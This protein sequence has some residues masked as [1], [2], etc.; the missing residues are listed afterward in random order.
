M[1]T[2]E[3]RQTY[4]DGK[5][6]PTSGELQAMCLKGG[7]G[8]KREMLKVGGWDQLA[9]IATPVSRLDKSAVISGTYWLRQGS[10]RMLCI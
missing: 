2:T 8:A 10:P 1:A 7:T 6:K 9:L 3:A 5:E 4:L